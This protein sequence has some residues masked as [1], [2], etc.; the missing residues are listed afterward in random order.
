[1]KSIPDV[2][3]THAAGDVMSIAETCGVAFTDMEDT[4]TPPLLAETPPS[5]GTDDTFSESIVVHN[6][7]PAGLNLMRNLDK[8]GP[9]ESVRP[10]TCNPPNSS[11]LTASN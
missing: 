3:P 7:Y 5:F 6:G 1:M 10:V 8:P 9:P 11:T 4:T 2:T